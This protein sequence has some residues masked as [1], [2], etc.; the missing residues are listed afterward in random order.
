MPK[1]ERERETYIAG[2]SCISHMGKL[3]IVLLGAHREELG[4]DLTVEDQ[5]TMIEFHAFHGL[6]PPRLSLRNATVSHIAVC[7]MGRRRKA[8]DIIGTRRGTGD[9]GNIFMR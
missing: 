6:V 7:I 8:S 5:V 4:R 2:G 9:E 3:S 1:R